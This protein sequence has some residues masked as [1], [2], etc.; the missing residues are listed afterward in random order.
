MRWTVAVIAG[1]LAL[2]GCA[3]TSAS[4]PHPDPTP[5]ETD[6]ALDCPAPTIEVSTAEELTDALAGAGPGDVIRLTDGRYEGEFELTSSGTADDPIWLCGSPDAV[7]DGGD[8][9]HG[10]VLH[11]AGV[12]NARLIGFG[13][14]NG[15]KGIMA[16]GVTD[17]VIS[18][19]IVQ[20]TGDEAIHL[21]DAST[22]NLVTAVT[23]R[24]TGLRKP[25]FGEGVYVGSAESNWCD[26]SDCEPDRSDRNRIVGNDIAGT[27]AESIDIKEGTA[28]GLVQGNTFD[29][30]AMDAEHADS[31]VD[32]KGNDW[33][34]EGN[35]GTSS[36]GDG[37]QTHEIVDGW[38]T[39]NRFS[40]N[41]AEVGGPGFGFAL[42]PER[43][44]V[45]D[46]DN[47]VEGAAQGVSNVPCRD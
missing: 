26:I 41:R 5:T 37:F 10:T 1:A 34:I 4:P 3:A 25:G 2:T 46:C 30:S 32:V 21:R 22:D 15:Q 20:H 24:D 13:V 28:D 47:V 27:T 16:D 18:G 45:V 44:N 33:T 11:L 38:G 9:Q 31:W 42:T 35:R 19:M 7:L 23:I 29:G 6:G 36:P 14:E 39:G 17:S 43:D 12:A 40:G 8:T